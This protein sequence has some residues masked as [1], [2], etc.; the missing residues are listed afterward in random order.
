VNVIEGQVGLFVWKTPFEG[1]GELICW[2]DGDDREDRKK[3]VK[4]FTTR[5]PAASFEHTGDMFKGLTPG[6][7][8]LSCR[9]KTAKDGGNT[10]RI[11]AVVAR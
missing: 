7:H 9:S 3:V 1:F 6:N 8:I 11:S 2:M 4:A 10:F 5:R